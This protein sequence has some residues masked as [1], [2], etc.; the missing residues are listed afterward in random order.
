MRSATAAASRWPRSS[1]AAQRDL[2][3]QLGR[4]A[5]AGPR[6]RRT[7]SGA[8]RSG[9]ATQWLEADVFA[10]LRRLRSEG[11]VVRST[12]LM[13]CRK[14]APTAAHAERRDARYIGHQP[15]SRSSCWRDGLL[16]T[17]SCSSG[18]YGGSCSRKIVAGAAP[19]PAQPPLVPAPAHRQRRV[20]KK[21]G[22]ADHSR[23]RLFEGLW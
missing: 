21:I 15:R 19:M 8:R 11:A 22:G 9:G 16:V 13:I 5:G 4:R 23:R 17:F 12:V 6:E 10:G 1:G 3:R 2:H 20:T 18:I 14:F 7:Q